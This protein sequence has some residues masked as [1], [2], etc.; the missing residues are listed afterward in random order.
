MTAN[1]VVDDACAASAAYGAPRSSDLLL[2]LRAHFS[3]R[4]FAAHFLPPC[5]NGGQNRKEDA[6]NGNI[7]KRNMALLLGAGQA[8]KRSGALR[9]CAAHRHWAAYGLGRG[10]ACCVKEVMAYMPNIK[11]WVHDPPA[12]TARVR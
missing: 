9:L 10:G 4:R 5:A 11:A 3:H 2:L 8:A 12:L 7:S 6:R 1:G